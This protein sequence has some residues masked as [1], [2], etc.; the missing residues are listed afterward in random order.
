MILSEE[1][2]LKQKQNRKLLANNFT[3]PEGLRPGKIFLLYL[4]KKKNVL[5][6]PHSLS[7]T[8]SPLS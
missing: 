3:G 6:F 4:K 1:G 8:R 7:L 2:S 5:L